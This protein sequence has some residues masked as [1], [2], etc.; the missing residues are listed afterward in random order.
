MQFQGDPLLLLNVTARG[1]LE[2][3]CFDILALTF[4]FCL[5]VLSFERWHLDFSFW[6][7]KIS[8][9]SSI[10]SPYMDGP[11]VF[12]IFGATGDLTAKK[13]MPAV[14]QLVVDKKISQEVFIIGVGRRVMP[15]EEFGA[16]M[17]RAVQAV[18]L[19]QFNEELWDKLASGIHY[20][21]GFFEEDALY[22]KLVDTLTIYDKKI[23]AC[24]PRFFY[25]ATP[26]EHYETILTH[27]SDSKL[28][29]GC[30]HGTNL[31]TRLLIEK[32]FGKDL[33]T[34]KHLEK[35]LSERFEERQIYRIDHYLGKETVQNL[36]AF[37]FANGMFEP[38]WNRE[39]ID[40]IQIVLGEDIGVGTR[41][42]FYEGVGALRD[43]VQNHMLAMLAITAMDQPT[44]FDALSIRDSR[45]AAMQ[46][47]DA[48][49]PVNV[50]ERVVRGQY[51]SYLSE[52][53]VDPNSK[54]E[55]FVAMR[56]TV[57]TARW[58]GVPF[59][60]RTGKK[61]R[62]KVTEIS[63]HYKK[64][65][66]CTGD[67]CL[68]P[69]PEVLR[70]VLTLKIQPNEG[71][72]LRLMAKQ[73]GYGMNLAPTEMHFSYKDSFPRFSSPEAYQ[74]L[75]LDAIRGDQTLFARSDEIDASWSIITKILDGWHRYDPAVYSYDDNSMG[76]SQANALIE[77]DG[78]HWYIG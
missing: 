4:E 54:T 29:E 37:R 46:A 19:E 12:V 15:L 47:I 69:E 30:G 48:I 56:L 6:T 68:F 71:I 5:R 72:T 66:V 32:P 14:Y 20:E 9:H 57:D 52:K 2:E 38:T 64:P 17:K 78:R 36:L 24:I 27:L 11:F 13:L 34:A 31:H 3:T 23:N 58:R 18:A 28:S 33:E 51:A 43:V 55:T 1:P 61:M 74:R 8:P 75:L 59:Y 25:L 35:V 60:L 73:P 50:P 21:Q 63:I 16:A 42:G 76:P 65:V 45:V 44:A 26:P 39:F 40:H 7:L 22:K 77:R 49:E 53:Q 41:G 10:V 70:N 62:E 67:V